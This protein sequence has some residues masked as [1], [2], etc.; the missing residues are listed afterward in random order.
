MRFPEAEMISGAI[1][2]GPLCGGAG[3][4]IGRGVGRVGE[5][6]VGLPT[7]FVV[8]LTLGRLAGRL[9]AVGGAPVGRGCP[10]DPVIVG[11][12]CGRLAGRL[13]ASIAPA[14]FGGGEPPAFGV[15]A[16][17]DAGAGLAGGVGFTGVVALEAPDLAAGFAAGFEA[18]FAAGLG[19]EFAAG[20]ADDVAGAFAGPV[21]GVFAA[22]FTALPIS[23][24]M[25]L[26]FSAMRRHVVDEVG[27]ATAVTPLIVIP[28]HD[29]HEL[30]ADH[31]GAEGVDD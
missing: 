13:D 22:G 27:D 29:L 1:R 7:G 26:F 2:R 19:E 28:G 16:A 3:R 8:A 31:H 14:G 25:K 20:F 12:T 17:F 4:G 18:G 9:G 10:L 5:P 21:A 23:R 6:P 11:F 24:E 30:V 15:G